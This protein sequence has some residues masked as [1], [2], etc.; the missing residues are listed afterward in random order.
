VSLG[1]RLY[2]V[3]R[4]ELNDATRKLGRK[5]APIPE[6]E[7][8]YAPPPPPAAEPPPVESAEAIEV[9]R[10]YANLELPFGATQTEVK[11]AYRRLMKQYHP[12]LHQDDPERAAAATKLSQQL[13]QAYEGLQAHFARR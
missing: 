4:A 6:V 10:F 8:N 2:N 3:A 9:R 13:R 5:G 12:D 1:R 7:P 11:A